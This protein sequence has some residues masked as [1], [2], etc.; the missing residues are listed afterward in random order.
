MNTVAIK[1][2][3]SA[4]ID[5]IPVEQFLHVSRETHFDGSLVINGIQYDARTID[6]GG[7]SGGGGVLVKIGEIDFNDLNAAA[8]AASITVAFAA[9]KPANK[10]LI[11]GFLSTLEAFV[12][13]SGGP[14]IRKSSRVDI[15]APL[16]TDSMNPVGATTVSMPSNLNQSTETARTVNAIINFNGVNPKDWESGVMGVYI[17]IADIPTLA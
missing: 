1:R 14:L 5:N 6:F 12:S 17:L 7:S 4:I 15:A 10:Y 8:A 9:A 13:Y 11:G 16:N 3:S 2:M